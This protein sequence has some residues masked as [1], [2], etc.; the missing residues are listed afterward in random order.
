VIASGLDAVLPLLACPHCAGPLTLQGPGVVGCE[1]GHRFDLARQGYLS[2]LGN[3]SRTDTGDSADMVE[4]R[5]A[6]LGAGHYRPIAD[7]IAAGVTQGPMLEIG[8][9]TGYYLGI[10]LDR[11]RDN[12]SEQCLVDRG[13]AL[14]ASR[15][16]ARRAAADPRIGSIVADAWSRLPIRDG[17]A[18][19]V[20]SVFAP[21]D[22]A[23][24]ARVLAP[25]GRLI[26]VTP[27]PDHLA[28]IRSAV[29]LLGVDPGKPGRLDEAFDG[30]LRSV[31]R[32]QVR[33]GMQL[34][35]GDIT[36]LVRMGPAARHVSPERLQASVTELAEITT[37]TM[38]VTVSVFAA[39]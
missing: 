22:P 38:A 10:A 27:E 4:A 19:T 30:H 32:A 3:R 6:F 15:Y 34:T 31:D 29:G 25:T 35:R 21:R 33:S 11:L 37:V 20:L 1:P 2:L 12:G 18:S 26:V 5:A 24:I 36:A 16:A 39:G 14:D 9:G 28:E 8:A 23:E 7:A 13:L 17:V